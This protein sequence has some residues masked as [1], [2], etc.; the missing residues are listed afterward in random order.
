MMVFQLQ[1]TKR[2]GIVPMTRDYIA[3]EEVRLRALEGGGRPPLRLGGGGF[4][5]RPSLAAIVKTL[6]SR[7]SKSKFHPV[8]SGEIR[9]GSVPGNSLRVLTCRLPCRRA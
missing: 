6:Y 2:Q 8:R 3:R 5:A 4:C 7:P 1:L 9:Q